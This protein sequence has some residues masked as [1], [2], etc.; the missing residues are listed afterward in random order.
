MQK[1]SVSPLVMLSSALTNRELI[2]N[3]IER[4]LLGRYQGSILSALWPFLIP[5]VMLSIYTFIFSMVF[6]ARWAL[7][8]D[9][10][11]EFALI[12]YLGLIV[13]NIFSDC[14]SSAP[15]LIIFHANYVNRVIFPL[16]VLPII[17]LGTALF[18]A[19]VSLSIWCIV[20]IVFIGLPPPTIIFIPIVIIPLILFTLGMCWLLAATGVFIR[21]I[22][23]IIGILIPALMFLSPIFYPIDSIPLRYQFLFKLNP[24]TPSIEQMRNIIMWGILPD[25]ELQFDYLI[26]AFL[27]AWLGFFVFQKFRK[28]FADVL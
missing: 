10:R 11:V 24:L 28:G 3:L 14:I 2:F 12:L 4:Q 18:N 15:N 20:H 8:S 7:A 17:S 22:S 21:D 25:W 5:V 23:Q 26:L 13:F 6:K 9:S 19:L 16:E 1:F 27:M